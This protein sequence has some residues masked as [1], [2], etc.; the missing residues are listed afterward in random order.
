MTTEEEKIYISLRPE[1]HTRNEKPTIAQIIPRIIQERGSFIDITEESLLHEIESSASAEEQDSNR[2]HKTQTSDYPVKVEPAIEDENSENDDSVSRTKP[3]IEDAKSVNVGDEEEDED[4]VDDIEEDGP[5]SIPIIGDSSIKDSESPEVAPTAA[6]VWCKRPTNQEEFDQARTELVRLIGVAQN[7]SALAQDFVSLLISCARPAAGTT[8]MSPH[9]KS[10][11]AVGSLGADKTK[12][13]PIAD[14]SLIGIG[15][16]IESLNKASEAMN[17]SASRLRLE[18]DKEKNYWKS[19]H[20]I[21]SSGEI[22]FKVRKGDSRG[23]G[24][25]FGFGDA[26]SDYKDKGVATVRRRGDGT[27]Y[28]KTN[29]ERRSKVVQ[30]S[31]YKKVDGEVI[32]QGVSSS[33]ILLPEN[34]VNNEIKNARTL[35]FEEE[36]FYV[37]ANEARPLTSHRISINNGKI[38]V[39]LQ[40]EEIDIEF[41]EPNDVRDN[42]D[43]QYLPNSRRAELIATTLR[44]LL[45]YSHAKHLRQ[46]H[47]DPEPLRT[48]DKRLR[49]TSYILRPLLCYIQHHK[50]LKRTTRSL[51]QMVENYKGISYSVEKYVKNMS[52]LGRILFPP[53]STCTLSFYNGVEVKIIIVSTLTNQQLPLYDVKAYC[54]KENT[55]L[56][57]SGF[58]Q[59]SELED[60]IK[61]VVD[62]KPI[63]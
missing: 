32:K 38:T 47:S 34:D 6:N 8:S 7:E 48:V 60:W 39:D 24:I 2:L 29:G 41:V 52:Y 55:I 35:L 54:N 19:I 30:I 46:K 5:N 49:H 10:H 37:I 36:L 21:A 59:L 44:L 31:I 62:K 58:Y 12:S 45:N 20:T 17:T 63:V 27:M 56:S 23:L 40:D 11:V 42:D 22:L 25:K 9:L 26:G 51:D 43:D 13:K 50:I 28:F 3:E 4:E 57:K 15:W 61:W 53:S 33:N 18:V 1:N 16:K 14:D